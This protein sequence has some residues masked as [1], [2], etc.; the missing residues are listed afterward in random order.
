MEK[1]CWG[2]FRSFRQ[3]AISEKPGYIISWDLQSSLF[4]LLLHRK[5][6]F[7]FINASIQHGIRLVRLSHI[8]RS[9]ICFLSPYV[10]ANS[11]AGLQVNNLKSGK[12]RFVLYNGIENKFKNTLTKTYREKQRNQVIPGY[13]EKPGNGLYYGC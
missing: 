6:N 1:H 2:K 7:K 9:L 3:I 12:R 8:F 13:T 4:S 11:F 5:Y 10:I